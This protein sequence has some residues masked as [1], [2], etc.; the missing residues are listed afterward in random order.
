M[1]EE[2]CSTNRKAGGVTHPDSYNWGCKER[3][4]ICALFVS[5]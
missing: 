1:E 2:N 5:Q 3:W 4:E